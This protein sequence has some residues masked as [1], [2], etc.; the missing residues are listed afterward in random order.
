MECKFEEMTQKHAEDIAFN[1]HYNGEFSFY[2]MESDKEDLIEF[3]DPDKRGNSHF[4]VMNDTEVIGFFSFNKVTQSTIDLGLGMRPDLT[5]NGHGLR[6][7]IAGI[8][9]AK[10]K[11]NPKK[12]TLSV[13]TFNQ[14]AIKVYRKLG[15]E[16]VETFMQDTNGS[17][18]EFLKMIYYW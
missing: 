11:Y 4:V 2:D 9:F 10:A 12:I 13:A 8:D 1:W 5:G 15:F 17:R 3:L 6:F 16:E 18:Y 7:L 14:R